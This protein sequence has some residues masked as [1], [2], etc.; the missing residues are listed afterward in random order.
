MSQPRVLYWGAELP[1]KTPSVS[2][3][4]EQTLRDVLLEIGDSP[5]SLSEPDVILIADEVVCTI[6]VK[7]RADNSAQRGH[8]R[9]QEYLNAASGLFKSPNNV[10]N[11]GYY[12]LTRNLVFTKLLAEKLNRRWKVINLGLPRIRTSANKFAELLSDPSV[13]EVETWPEVCRRMPKPRLAWFQDYL[14][15]KG[16]E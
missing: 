15:Q 1:S 3:D 12:E 7:Y 13:F 8:R 9:F 16:L 6:E 4:I 2:H 10:T 5:S 14:Q 11:A